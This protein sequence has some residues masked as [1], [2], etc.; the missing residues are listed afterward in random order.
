[1]NILKQNLLENS[2]WVFI[3][4]Y[5]SFSNNFSW[6]E[7][8]MLSDAG[9]LGW[10]LSTVVGSQWLLVR[11]AEY[12]WNI[13]DDC[14]GNLDLLSVHAEM[15]DRDGLMPPQ[16]KIG[17]NP[18]RHQYCQYYLN[19]LGVKNE[20]INYWSGCNWNPLMVFCIDMCLNK[21]NK[22]TTNQAW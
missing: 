6:K 3:I 22:Y 14:D 7:R 13:S 16:L 8:R 2:H 11:T 9:L 21:K 20:K 18:I 10:L 15:G 19:Y 4:Y 17:K 12:Q 5:F 1:M